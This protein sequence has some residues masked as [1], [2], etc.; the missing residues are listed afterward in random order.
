[1]NNLFQNISQEFQFMYAYYGSNILIA[2]ISFIVIYGF[3]SYLASTSTTTPA[4]TMG[5]PVSD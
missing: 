3:I 1:M 2:T 5:I 4:G